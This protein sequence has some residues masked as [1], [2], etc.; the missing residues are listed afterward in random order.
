MA[1]KKVAPYGSWKSPVT[2]DLIVGETIRFGL[3][4]LDGDDIYWIEGR[5]SEGGRNV[6]VRCSPDGTLTDL[7]PQPFNAR[8]RVHEYGGGDYVVHDGTLYF[9]NFSDQRLYRVAPSSEPVALTPAIERRYADMVLDQRRQRLV[10]ICEDHTNTGR[11]AVNML[12]SIPL[13][14]DTN[15]GSRDDLQIL[16]AGNDF[17]AAPRLS[18]D[19]SQLCWLTWNHPNMPWDGC[20]LWVA[21][22]G[23]NGFVENARRV[24]GGAEESIF[25]PS[26]SPDGVLY[27][28]SDRTNWWNIYRVTDSGVEAVCPREAEFGTPHWVFGLSTYDFVSA[29]RIICWYGGPSGSA[30]AYLDTRSGALTPIS[31]PF[32]SVSSIRTNAKHA[33][34]LGA[35]ATSTGAIVS[36]DI[37]TGKLDVLRRAQSAVVDTGYI[38][39]AQLIEFPTE[40]GLTAYANYYAPKNADYAAPEGELPPLLVISHGGPTSAA[41]S[42]L[43]LSTQFWTSRGFAVVDVN[44]GGSSGYGRAY[45]DRLKGQ[46][47]VVDVE[48]CVNAAKYLVERGLVDSNRLT[49]QGGSAGGYTTLCALT[50][51]DAFKAGASHFGVSDLNVFVHDTHK[52]ESR[53]LY[54]LI[55]PYPE[56]K[57]L[58]YERSAINYIDRL[59]CPV[60]FFQGLE[61]KIV[62]PSQAELMVEALRAKKVPVAYVPFEGEQH[63]FRRAENIKRSLE[64]ELYFYSKVFHFDLAEPIEPVEIENL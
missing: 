5:P 33:I 45:R 15:D 11:E 24:A 44:Y 26:W 20:E 17:Y 22:L 54:G 50:F 19:G 27:F 36:L 39:D 21:N 47:G 56:R 25:Q 12:V 58:Y 52:F 10:C 1:N 57:D 49:I 60:I 35:S 63:G 31:L 61:D 62:P 28:V 53:Y 7:V 40:N 13:N 23:E 16:Q 30:L 55:G 32:S 29:D 51:S 4:A 18:P 48:D 2:T 9:S 3:T 6:V 42:A 64:A 14:G 38:S 41:S 59:S 43:K 46:W 8:T 34:F 37:A